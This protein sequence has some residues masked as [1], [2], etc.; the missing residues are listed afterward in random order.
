MPHVIF[1]LSTLVVPIALIG[2]TSLCVH[3]VWLTKQREKIQYILSAKNGHGVKLDNHLQYSPM[4][5]VYGLNAMGIK[6]AHELADRTG[7]LA[8][9]AVTMAVLVNGMKY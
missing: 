8:M 4:V 5:A 6:G 2:T 3:T 7:I 1:K 9:S